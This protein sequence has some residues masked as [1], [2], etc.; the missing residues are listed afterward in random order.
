MDFLPVKIDISATDDR[1][2]QAFKDAGVSSLF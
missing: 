2:T 1:L